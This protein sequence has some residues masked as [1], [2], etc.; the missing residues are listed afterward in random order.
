VS[1]STTNILARYLELR[2]VQRELNGVLTKTLSRKA[3]EET[4]RRLGFWEGGRIVFDDEGDVDILNDVALYDYFPSGGK[5]AVERYAAREELGADQRLV[6]DA[7]CRARFTLIE[8]EDPVPKVGVQVLDLL[9]GE[10]FLLADV[11]LSQ[12]APFGLALATRILRFDEFSMTS[13]VHRVFDD[14]LTKLVSGPFAS[15]MDPKGPPESWSSRDRSALARLLL[16]LA[17]VEPDEARHM[18][19]AYAAASLPSGD[20]RRVE[21]AR[22][23]ARLDENTT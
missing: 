7:M 1:A 6:M 20:P 4:A 15:T 13:G 21:Y 2:S 8:V 3:I 18:L 17:V 14:T 19:A 23:R 22:L 16:Q 9:F 12:T 5:N 11:A 10:R